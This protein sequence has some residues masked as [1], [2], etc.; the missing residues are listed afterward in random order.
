VVPT[1]SRP[2]QRWYQPFIVVSL[3]VVVLGATAIAKP[4]GGGGG[5]GGKCTKRK[6]CDT[7]AP[8]ITI[9][10]PEAG[11]SASG[12]VTIEG[13]STDDARV[14]TVDIRVDGASAQ[15]AEG[16]TSWSGQLDTT[17]LPD[18]RHEIAA[19]ATDAAGN[20][21]IASVSIDV[22]NTV[23]EEPAPGPGP[24][25][26]PSP[27][28]D[29]PPA[30]TAAPVE[31]SL[32]NGSIG[33][34]IFQETDRDGVYETGETAL[35]GARA[36]LFSASGAYLANT[37]ADRTGWYRFDGLA[38]G[39]YQVK[40][41]PGAWSD[42][43]RDWAP[44]TTGSERPWVVVNL[45]GS[46]HVDL[47]WRP[48]V[49]STD[50]SAPISTF[51]APNGLKIASYND[52]VPA[53]RVWDALTAGELM[54]AEAPNTTLRF[55]IGNGDQCTSSTMQVGGVYKQFSVGCTIEYT[56]WLD[57]GDQVL[58]HEYGH[59]WGLYHAYI[60]QQDTKL[61]SYLAARGIDPQDPRL[62]TSHAW[63]RHEM[64]A[65]DYRQ[66]F[67]SPNARLRGQENQDIPPAAEVP[68]LRGFLSTTFMGADTT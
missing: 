28:S 4:P 50:L 15:P 23:P 59:A 55:D 61:T 12:T 9:S 40:Y 45:A 13:T 6:P 20:I 38:D 35:G 52:V 44:S 26:A 32:S 21:G 8:V 56:R 37:P 39:G 60:V 25:P 33:G 54:G 18:G 24:A 3:I 27:T 62:G 2:P 43:W 29:P 34:W 42:L 31:A 57:S 68:G 36:Y 49:R 19:V 66:L 58:F 65:E 53:E 10:T 14:S 16:T 67:G 1:A 22:V 63:S 51:T 64:L 7:T 17:S 46:A 47:G 41:D 5:Q 30:D 11:S 48:I